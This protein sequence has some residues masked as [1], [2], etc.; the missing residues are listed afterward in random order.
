MSENNTDIIIHYATHIDEQK[1]IVEKLSKEAS[2]N[3]EIVIHYSDFY[4]CVTFL[5]EKDPVA[6]FK[7]KESFYEDRSF[8]STH[9]LLKAHKN[10]IIHMIENKFYTINV[11][12]KQKEDLKFDTINEMPTIL[13][14]SLQIVLISLQIVII[15]LFFNYHLFE[16]TLELIK[17]LIGMFACLSIL[18]Y[19]AHFLNL[20]KN[21]IL[22]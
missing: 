3:V 20:L 6:T 4:Y 1:K 9:I 11:F 12:D 14:A 2:E 21:K 10:K 22:N 5:N 19:L 17:G 18:V 16:N 13:K 8:C 15:Y 7:I